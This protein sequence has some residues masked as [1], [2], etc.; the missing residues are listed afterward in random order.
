MPGKNPD[1]DEL[2]ASASRGD[3]SA[4]QQLLVRHR[5]RLKK[6]VRLHM[7]RRLAPRIDPSDVV[8][9]AL[10]EAAQELSDYLAERPIPFYPWLRKIAWER[11]VKLHRR[12][13]RARKRNVGREEPGILNLP[14]ESAVQLAGR[15]LDLGSSPSKHLLREELHARVQT[16]LDQLPDRDREVLVLRYLEQLSTKETAA[17]LG[18]SE[19]AVKTRHLRALVRLRERLGADLEDDL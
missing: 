10:A 12:H 6:M 15:L 13:L 3:A 9:E 8:Q 5:R 4:R 1:T 7:D 14:D 2:L 17:V 19:S 11:L 18:I 16:A